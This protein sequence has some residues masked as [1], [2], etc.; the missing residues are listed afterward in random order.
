MRR[1]E[2]HRKMSVG[3]VT[4]ARRVTGRWCGAGSVKESGFVTLASKDGTP[5]YRRKQ[6]QRLAHFVVG[7]AIAKL[8]WIGTLRLWNQR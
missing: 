8:V 3:V 1:R 2:M 4:S 6:L 5:V 7:I